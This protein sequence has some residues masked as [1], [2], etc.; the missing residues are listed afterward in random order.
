MKGS[1]PSEITSGKEIARAAWK[2]VNECVRDQD[3]QGGVISGIGT[4]YVERL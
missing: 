4:F 2:L 3:H 1:A